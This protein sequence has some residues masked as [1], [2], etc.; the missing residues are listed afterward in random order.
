MF[1]FDPE[2]HTYTLDDRRLESV[3]EILKPLSPSD[4][5]TEEGRIRGTAIHN[6]VSDFHAG[7]DPDLPAEYAAY[8]DGYIQFC[9]DY[10]YEP[11]EVEVPLYH[12]TMRYAGTPDSYGDSALGRILPDVKTGAFIPSYALQTAGYEELIVNTT[13]LKKFTRLSVH[14]TTEGN[15]R[16]E[17]HKSFTDRSV[18]ISALTLMRWRRTH[19]L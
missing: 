14:I 17:L 7:K 3:T 16:V 4:F 19:N 9:H 5:Y 12:R 15:Y 8:L 13:K 1:S 2:T 18:F 10:H 6:A 11:I